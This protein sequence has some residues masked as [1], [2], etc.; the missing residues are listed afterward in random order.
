MIIYE[1]AGLI[2]ATSKQVSLYRDEFTNTHTHRT[3]DSDKFVVVLV[4][5]VV[6]VARFAGYSNSLYY[7]R[8]GTGC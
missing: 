4:V 8:A 7:W 3:R 6:S 5:V 2:A 1:L